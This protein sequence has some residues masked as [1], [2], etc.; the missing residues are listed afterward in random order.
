M[1]EQYKAQ[2]PQLGWRA[3]VSQRRTWLPSLLIGVVAGLGGIAEFIL[4]RGVAIFLILIAV[5]LAVFLVSP[6]AIW[7]IQWIQ[8]AY[9]R[10]RRYPRVLEALATAERDQQQLR[11]LRRG[12]NLELWHAFSQGARRAVRAALHARDQHTPLEIVGRSR[13]EGKVHLW[14]RPPTDPRIQR[15]DAIALLSSATRDLW[16]V[17]E[18][19]QVGLDRCRGRVARIFHRRF[20]ERQVQEAETDQSPPTGVEARLYTYD[21]LQSEVEALRQE[22]QTSLESENG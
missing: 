6:F 3:S 9:R 16:A 10:V 11:A 13:D 17:F 15:G 19:D 12:M 2:S 4:N 18:V 1:G 20:W 5:A 22:A 14:F 8:E 21:D 7:V